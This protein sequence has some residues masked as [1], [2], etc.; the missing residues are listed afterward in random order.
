MWNFIIII[1]LVGGEIRFRTLRFV[2]DDS[3]WLREAPIYLA[4]VLEY[5][6]TE[7]L[8]LTGNIAK[9]NKYRIMPRH[10]LLALR[11][12]QE[13]RRL[14]TGIT[15]AHGGVLP[16]INPVLLPKRMAEKEPKEGKLAKKAAKSPK[17]AGKKA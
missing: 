11:N 12:D 1:M 10:L 15:I 7:L 6:A 14:L 5:L 9:E 13:L 8:E 3:A 17:K 4:V 16:N 2:A